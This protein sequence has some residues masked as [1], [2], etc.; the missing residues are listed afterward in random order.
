MYPDFKCAKSA[1]CFGPC[2]LFVFLVLAVSHA[3]G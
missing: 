3:T 1:G 2:G